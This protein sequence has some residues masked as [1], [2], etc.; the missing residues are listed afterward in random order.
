MTAEPEGLDGNASDDGTSAR[1]EFL[2]KAGKYA[3]VTPPLVATMLAVTS[4]PALANGSGTSGGLGGHGPSHGSG[5]SGGG[6]EPTKAHGSHGR[7]NAHGKARGRGKAHGSSR[8]SQGR[9]K[10]RSR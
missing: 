7:G 4:T 3:A 1:R 5:G 2:L 6:H 9:Q 10:S 8:E